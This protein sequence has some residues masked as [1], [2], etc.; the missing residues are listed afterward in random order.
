[1]GG[2]GASWQAALPS[3]AQPA[4]PAGTGTQ[5]GQQASDGRGR[6]VWRPGFGYAATP[7]MR[8]ARPGAQA[9]AGAGTGHTG[10]MGRGEGSSGCE[11]PGCPSQ[12][13]GGPAAC[14]PQIGPTAWTRRDRRAWGA[15]CCPLGQPCDRSESWPTGALEGQRRDEASTADRDLCA[16]REAAWLGQARPQS[17]TLVGSGAFDA[18]PT[19]GRRSAGSAWAAV[20][21]G[22]LPAS[23]RL[24][25]E[26]PPWF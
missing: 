12:P 15:L 7:G 17:P 10:Q 1:M 20:L 9:G 3:G 2:A 18:H 11:G 8:A 16:S 22:L 26:P 4:S 23:S 21:T 14:F 24:P 19:R 5:V 25:L 6:R 13:G